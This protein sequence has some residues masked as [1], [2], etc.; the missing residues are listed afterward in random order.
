MILSERNVKTRKEHKCFGC[1]RKMPVGTQ[2]QCTTSPDMGKLITTYWCKTC[3][4]Y[5]KEYMQPD[6]EIAQGDLRYEDKET[7][8][9]V[10]QRVEKT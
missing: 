1:A 6:D 7:W 4:E 2:M 8:E 10:R 9:A 3:Q 5:W